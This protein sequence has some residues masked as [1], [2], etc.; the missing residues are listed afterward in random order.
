MDGC[1]RTHSHSRRKCCCAIPRAQ[2]SAKSTI[3]SPGWPS[4]DAFLHSGR[5]RSA[6]SLALVVARV[7][8]MPAEPSH[9]HATSGEGGD[10]CMV[11][12]QGGPN[13]VLGGRAQGTHT[14][15]QCARTTNHRRHARATESP[16]NEKKWAEWLLLITQVTAGGARLYSRHVPAKCAAL[17]AVHQQVLGQPA[18]NGILLSSQTSTLTCR[19][20]FLSCCSLLRGVRSMQLSGG[21]GAPTCTT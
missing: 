13:V 6:P 3:P 20:N 1:A 9:Q 7:L 2:L 18:C 11:G 15:R 14:Q 8:Q 17:L 5:A 19:E 16:T 21:K 4:C 10:A 12:S